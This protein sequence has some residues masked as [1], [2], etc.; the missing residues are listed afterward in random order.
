LAKETFSSERRFQVVAPYEPNGDQPQAIQELTRYLKDEDTKFCILKGITGTGKTFVMSHVLAKSQRPTLVLCHNK[1]LAAQLA[2]ELRSFLPYNAV[3]LFV[4]YYNTYLP[5][6][7]AES[8]GTYTSKKCS[9]N[10]DIDT[11]RHRATRA[12][13]ERKDVVVVA[14][15]SCIFG[16]GLPV[17][18]LDAALRLNLHEDIEISVLIERLD[19]MRYTISEAEGDIGRGNYE[20]CHTVPNQNVLTVWPPHERYPIRL[21]FTT[22]ELST[23]RLTSIITKVDDKDE[24]GGFCSHDSYH[25]FP[26]KHHVYPNERL[27]QA[28]Q[29]IEQELSERL[30]ELNAMGKAC[31]AARLQNKV[32]NDL[33]IL[34]ETGFCNGAENYSRHFS[35]KS[36]GDPPDTLIDYFHLTGNGKWLLIVDE[37]HVTLPQLKAMYKGNISRK[38]MLVKHGYR[39]PSALDH[40]PLRENEFWNLISQVIFVSATPAKKE[41]ELTKH[42]PVEMIIR[43]TFICDPIIEVRSPEGQLENLL[44]EIKVRAQRKERTLALALT[45]RDAEDLAT[46]LSS[47]GVQATYIHSGLKIQERSDALK[48]LQNG[49]VDC[50]VGVNL[51]REGL[52]LPQVSL[53]AILRADAEGFLRSETAL[54]QTVGRAARNTNGMAFFFASRVTE[55][56]QRCIEATE[57]RRT[58][59]LAY[60]A[61]NNRTPVST[62]G[63]TMMSLF[64][65][66]AGDIQNQGKVEADRLL[67]TSERTQPVILALEPPRGSHSGEQSLNFF[68]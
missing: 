51:L 38:Q 7:Y 53:V 32:I 49:S 11:L 46:Y 31:E 4:S 64:D 6:S 57:R 1:T 26:A 45:K 13:F 24:F 52:D 37:S 3:E 5:E 43:P 2:R 16:L 12:L 33:M 58:L 34:R 19:S 28:C 67:L 68:C 35:N 8:S 50:L 29:S 15:V 44:N 63:S 30:A 25:I 61:E 23:T 40:R 21:E 66:L 14:S 42:K 9:I 22:S 56:M 17:D 10:D 20:L 62:K 18:Y 55:S 27:E 36:E 47:R 39:L 41:I 59:Q 54:L 65:L 48:S 60:N